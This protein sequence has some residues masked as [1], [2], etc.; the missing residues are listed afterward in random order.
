MSRLSISL[1][2]PFQ[3]ALDE[4]PALGFE[5]DKVRAL[6]AYLA[7]E[8]DRLHRRETLAGLLWPD[9]PERSA[10]KNLRT[11]L[12][13]LRRVI[14]DREGGLSFLHITRQTIQF[15]AA[16]DYE[17]DVATFATLLAA[18]ATSQLGID[19]LQEAVAL[20]QGP[21]LEGFSIPDSTL[22]EEWVLLKR[23]ELGR[24][25]LQTLHH[26]ADHY[27]QQGR[28][29]QALP[30]A[31]R[32]LELEPWREE[33]HQQ[34]MCLLAVEGQRSE[35]LAQYETCRRLLAEELGV[36]PGAET[37]RLY[38]QIRNGELSRGAGERGSRGEIS[39]V[40][41][42][43]LP[44]QTTPFVGRE[45][46]LAALARLLAEP[47]LRLVTIVGAGGMGKT[48]LA[49]EVAQTQ[50]E[51]FAHGVYFVRLAPLET[52]DA[53][54]A[55]IA[56]ALHFTFYQGSPPEQ[57]LRDYLRQK[58]VLLMMDNFEHLLAG[59]EVV[60]DLL[61]VAPGL[62]VLA[63][64][65]ARLNLREEQL[66]WVGGI[67]FPRLA[68]AGGGA[69]G[70]EL[71][72]YSAVRL[73]GQSAR[74]VRP[75]FELTSKALQEVAHICRLVEGMPLA[76]ILAAAWVEV[77]TP[78][79]IAAEIRQS[80]DFLETELGDVPDRQRSMRAVFDHSWRLLSEPE[81]EAFQQMS[82]FRGGFTR[83]AA[84]QVIGTSLR[85]LMAL[86]N[87]SFLHRTP[88]G[89]YEIHELLRQYAAEKLAQ[90]PAA[91]EAARDRH[92]AYYAA[93][94]GEREADLKG[95]QQQ[96]A[97]AEIE[98]DRENIRVAWQW[99]AERGQIEQLGS[100]VESLGRFYNWRGRY[101]EGE[102]AYQAAAEKLRVTVSL[103]PR[104][105]GKRQ[106]ALAKVLAWQGLFSF[107]LGRSEFAN[108]LLQQSWGILVG[109][110][111]A[112]QDTS[113]EKAFILQ[114][115]GRIAFD[116]DREETR[117]LYRQSLAL[118]QACGDRWGTAGVL[119]ELGLVAT[120]VAAF[121]EAKQWLE[122]SLTILRTLGDQ[123]GISDT[124]LALGET[125]LYQE[126]LEEAERLVQEGITL[127]REMGNRLI[128]AQ[129][130]GN[131]G[132]V[133]LLSGKFAEAQTLYQE[134]LATWH[135][136]GIRGSIIDENRML[137]Y[138]KMHLGRYEEAREQ[139]ELV[140]NLSREA[141]SPFKVMFAL[142][143]LSLVALAKEKYAE[144]QQLARE[145]I[146]I[147][148]VIEQPEEL[149]GALAILGWT[150]YKL[151]NRS[152]VGRHLAE[153]LQ[154]AVETRSFRPAT[155]ILPVLAL[156]LLEQGEPERAVELYALAS[157]HPHVANSRW[158]EDVAG[159]HIAA[160]A[161]TLP[162]EVVAA[163]QARGRARDVWQTAEE[164]L[165][166][167]ER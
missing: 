56:E 145:A 74:R 146:A 149:A 134:S 16:S 120:F 68:L 100:M 39:F 55:T 101:R 76:I 6:L 46:E 60:V 25:V 13:N 92:S 154:I 9:F 24:Q 57:Q 98:A 162:P 84:Q 67:D 128:V 114:Q 155:L 104:A 91:Q 165:A 108:Q 97:M 2:G 42:H 58:E 136:L 159:R 1:L 102:T 88:T 127:G 70:E 20:Y 43:N 86:V 93:F 157:R 122:Q 148:R 83:Q 143:F 150:T 147:S 137:G 167:L 51:H 28:Y 37:K 142:F 22:F 96:K 47:E 144:T 66:F 63:T 119:Y 26:L 130:L 35:A 140:L 8:V 31:W 110:E 124:L 78:G 90:S 139:L 116:S 82:V 161:E 135:E 113:P 94:L 4:K 117:R 77:L 80:L 153:A 15:N 52:P 44:V 17:L 163:A 106:W 107:Q 115:M 53:I 48:R 54:V 87:K 7:V 103:S 166:E 18:D 3:V 19:S 40:P 21:F 29:D 118:Y 133:S 64:S 164:L 112:N 65:R 152:D 160:V 125:M 73:F 151:G 138:A 72:R 49:L 81:R 85:T 71:A 30:Y 89:R 33:A 105:S 121:D 11:A 12:A 27:E 50:L 158:F 95:A 75:A 10:R 61:K 23:E 141:G 99:A 69:Q 32:Q 41:R 38:E 131:L 126:Q 59:V 14:G 79:E 45:R 111:L 34:L 156:L 132:A 123:K 36:E 109:P 129:G 5:S 62:K